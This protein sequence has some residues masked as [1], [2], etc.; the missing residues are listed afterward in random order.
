LENYNF[1][2]IVSLPFDVFE[3]AYIDT[4]I[5]VFEKSFFIIFLII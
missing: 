5:F 1:K 2:Q 3:D 4:G